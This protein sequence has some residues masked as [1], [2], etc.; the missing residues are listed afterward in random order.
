MLVMA[1]PLNAQSPIDKT[2]LPIVAYFR[3]RQPENEYAPIEVTLSGIVILV[4]P[5][6]LNANSPI[7][8]TLFGIVTLV[9]SKQLSNAD[10]PIVVTILGIEYDVNPTGAN[11]FNTP[12]TIKHLLSADAYFP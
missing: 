4:K 9:K 8:V 1:A 11:E 10:S 3:S 2:P 7:E 12:L 6:L 5:Q